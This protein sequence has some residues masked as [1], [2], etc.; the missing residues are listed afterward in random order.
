MRIGFTYDLK[1]D[2][3]HLGLEPEMI[4][5]FDSPKTIDGI[6]AALRRAG[7]ETD[8]IGHIK[9]LVVRL[10]KGDRWDFVFNITEGLYGAARES[11]VPALLDAYNIPYVFSD[12]AALALSL[13]KALSKLVFEAHGLPTAP[14]A[15]VRHEAEIASV[16]L[17]FPLFAKPVADGTGKGISAASRVENK[18][19]LASICRQLLARYGQPVLVEQYLSGREF[20]VGMLGA[21]KRSRVIGIMEIRIDNQG[22][23]TDYGY[24]NKIDWFDGL[25]QTL[26]DR[27]AEPV[28]ASRVESMAIG[29]WN[30][31]DCRD[32]GRLD[33]RCDEKGDPYLLEVNPLAGLS[34]G[35]SDLCVLAE[36]AGMDYNTLIGSILE[37]FF[38]RNPGLQ[39][40]EHR[41]TR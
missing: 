27:A 21:G 31:L 3:K 26:L 39:R 34:P 30:A 28:L 41:A 29:A 36:L 5:E 8:R 16:N 19:Q 32:G 35:F 1:D 37:E 15:V 9:N 18:E 38:V 40:V 2:Y 33:I 7:H 22:E 25:N 17:P 10:A 20:T 6:D 12:P 4:A 13:D 11:Q 14:F 23:N 24:Q